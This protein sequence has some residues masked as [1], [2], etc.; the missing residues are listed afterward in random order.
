MIWHKNVTGQV[1]LLLLFRSYG[2]FVCFL[3]RLK[4]N[5][6]FQMTGFSIL[7]SFTEWPQA[8]VSA[9]QPLHPVGMFP[10]P[11]SEMHPCV[12]INVEE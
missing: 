12:D 8:M 1:L 6:A 7:G 5:S 9:A 10:I 4:K 11:G 2:F 3:V